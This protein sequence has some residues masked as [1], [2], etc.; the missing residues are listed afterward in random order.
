MGNCRRALT[1]F[2]TTKYSIA[3]GSSAFAS[4][5]AA[6]CATQPAR[7][8]DPTTL[9]SWFGEVR[10]ADPSDC[11]RRRHRERR[12]VLRPARR[13]RHPYPARSL[14]SK[15]SPTLVDTLRRCNS[16]KDDWLT[17]GKGSPLTEFALDGQMAPDGQRR[18][19]LGGT[20]SPR[21]CSLRSISALR[22]RNSTRAAAALSSLSFF[23]RRTS[24]P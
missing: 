11:T 20:C 7:N 16:A 21:S 10:R 8:G 18:R 19:G 17:T 23:A 12:P 5:P 4:G 3:K 15:A 14:Q 2:R 22:A 24:R 13:R 9:K 6:R 1:Q